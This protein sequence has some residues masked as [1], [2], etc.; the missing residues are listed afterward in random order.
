MSPMIFGVA[1]V[2]GAGAMALWTYVRFPDRGPGELRWIILHAAGAWAVLHFV[3]GI[4]GPFVAAGLIPGILTLVGIA[5]PGVAYA[6]LVC[7]WTIKMFQGA[8]ASMG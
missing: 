6:F 3:G 1:F 5:L 4:V 2:F 7:I 8:R